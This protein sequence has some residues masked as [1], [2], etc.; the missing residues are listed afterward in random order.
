M[1]SGATNRTSIGKLIII[2]L[3]SMNDRTSRSASA[4]AARGIEY[5]ISTK[6]TSLGVTKVPL[7]RFVSLTGYQ[8]PRGARSTGGFSYESRIP[9][10]AATNGAKDAGKKAGEPKKEEDK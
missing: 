1:S 2:P 6:W 5:S 10:S 4:T 7:R 8:L 9:S 3:R